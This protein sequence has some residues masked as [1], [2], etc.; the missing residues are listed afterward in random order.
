[1][2]ARSGHVVLVRSE[3]GARY[4]ETRA[5]EIELYKALPVPPEDVAPA[6]IL[7]FR[8]RRREELLALQSFS[9]LGML[10]TTCSLG[11]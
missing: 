2:V 9:H 10:W 5:V 4:C 11:L 6:D 8:D 1:M 7:E 3:R